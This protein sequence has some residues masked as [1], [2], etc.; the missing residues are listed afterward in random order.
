LKH[1]EV[2]DLLESD[3]WKLIEE[4]AQ[5]LAFE[6]FKSMACE[7]DMLAVKYSAAKDGYIE[8]AIRILANG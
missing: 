1:P 7:S 4:T 8:R 6:D 3:L 2:K 5:V